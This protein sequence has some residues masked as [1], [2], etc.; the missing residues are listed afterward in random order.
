M[1]AR[2]PQ[3]QEPHTVRRIASPEAAGRLAAVLLQSASLS[4]QAPTADDTPQIFGF[5]QFW[6]TQPTPTADSLSGS[7]SM[8]RTRVGIRGSVGNRVSYFLLSEVGQLAPRAPNS[9]IGVSLVDALITYRA[10]P[11]LRVSAGQDYFRLGLEGSMLLPQIHFV[12]RSEAVDAFYLPLGRNGM[13][14]YDSGVKIWGERAPGDRTPLGYAV[15]VHNGTGLNSA[16]VNGRKDVLARAWV[17]PRIVGGGVGPVQLGASFFTG[18]SWMSAEAPGGPLREDLSERI[19]GVDAMVPLRI[20]RASGR[21]FGEYL[22]GDY[23]GSTRLPQPVPE[24]DPRGWYV[25]AGLTPLE[26]LEVL[27][28]ESRYEAERG[29]REQAVYTTTV[30]FRARLRASHS[31][32]VN[33]LHK[34]PGAQY[35][36]VG[37][38]GTGSLALA[39]WELTF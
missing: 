16:D 37:I 5:A 24:R 20:G 15:F 6:W 29:V 7:F 19:L 34:R 22:A 10:H 17:A 3:P 18:S 33:Y 27:A 21:I 8:A 1:V 35:R 9:R 30:G 11:L 38:G 12:L 26:G 2:S 23:E 39:Q 31:L 14:A 32:R 36:P 25:A 4:A 28:R 13:Y